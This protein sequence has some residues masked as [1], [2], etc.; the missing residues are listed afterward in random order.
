MVAISIAGGT[1]FQESV[2][3]YVK[4]LVVLF[5]PITEV[6]TNEKRC[7]S[8]SFSFFLDAHLPQK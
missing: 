3:K 4:A 5:D 1:D 8:P 2:Q 7:V 6:D